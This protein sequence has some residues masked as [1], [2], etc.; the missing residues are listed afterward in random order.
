MAPIVTPLQREPFNDAGYVPPCHRRRR[1]LV[2]AAARPRPRAATVVSRSRCSS[3]IESCSSWIERWLAE[4]CHQAPEDD[5]NERSERKAQSNNQRSHRRVVLFVCSPLS[6]SSV[7]VHSTGCSF[8][9]HHSTRAQRHGGR[10]NLETTYS[11]AIVLLATEA[12]VVA[13]EVCSTRN[14]LQICSKFST[15]QLNLYSR[16]TEASVGISFVDFCFFF[17]KRSFF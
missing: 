13:T 10:R 4:Y 1:R 12:S 14:L 7:Y 8:P 3:W 6:H 16:T 2:V 17:S 9:P 15:L 5:S 11:L